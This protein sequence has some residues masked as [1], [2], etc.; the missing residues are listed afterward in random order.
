MA[1]GILK[2]FFLPPHDSPGCTLL[3]FLTWPWPAMV[4]GELTMPLAISEIVLDGHSSTANTHLLP[5]TRLAPGLHSSHQERKWAHST[6][7]GWGTGR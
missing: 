4:S 2:T 7:F 5:G 6:E 3:R 1:S